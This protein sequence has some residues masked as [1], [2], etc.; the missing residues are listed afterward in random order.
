M[1]PLAEASPAETDDAASQR[2]D[3]RA[4]KRPRRAPADRGGDDAM[5]VSI[6]L[7]SPPF[8]LKS[9]HTHAQKRPRLCSTASSSHLS[10][11][12]AHADSG[13]FSALTIPP[14]QS[15]QWQQA[16]QQMTRAIELR[17][18]ADL[19]FY[20]AIFNVRTLL[21]AKEFPIFLEIIVARVDPS[22]TSR[23]ILTAL[24]DYSNLLKVA[25]ASGC[26]EH[27]ITSLLRTPSLKVR[28]RHL[29]QLSRSLRKFTPAMA[30]LEEVNGVVAQLRE[31]LWDIV[32]EK[33]PPVV[34]SI[35]MESLQGNMP[36]L[37]ESND[38]PARSLAVERPASEPRTASVP[39][40][41]RTSRSRTPRTI[42]SIQLSPLP[43]PLPAPSRRISAQ[44][45]VDS[46]PSSS[47]ASAT[48]SRSRAESARVTAAPTETSAAKINRIIEELLS[49]LNEERQKVSLAQKR[50]DTS[51]PAAS[52]S[53]A[54]EDV[55]LPSV[56]N[57]PRLMDLHD[58]ETPHFWKKYGY[59]F[60]RAKN[61][62]GESK[63]LMN[64]FVRSVRALVSLLD[65]PN[66]EEEPDASVSRVACNRRSRACSL[67]DTSSMA[68]RCVFPFGFQISGG[69]WQRELREVLGDDWK[70]LEATWRLIVEKAARKIGI[71][72]KDL[73]LITPK[74]LI[75]LPGY[76]EQLIHVSHR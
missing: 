69:V 65:P 29:E 19:L 11:S 21:S 67:R 46:V 55:A 59:A 27:F 43:T 62:K 58:T 37:R 51:K 45:P 63:R 73:Y 34:K 30:T 72:M 2:T 17:S 10:P 32:R 22:R 25:H 4:L 12:D 48:R 8:S 60:I 76:G 64:T 50:Q 14:E 40:P 33:V 7:L 54:M 41:P 16:I 49:V 20:S 3:M 44:R 53:A 42:H 1:A 26:S 15:S 35:K 66:I 23:F 52:G 24:S 47:S 5:D 6:D 70:V 36:V 18:A 38:L 39:S 56:P 57:P 61:W 31:Q 68:H 28:A 75:A 13:L 71:D 74:C 9:E